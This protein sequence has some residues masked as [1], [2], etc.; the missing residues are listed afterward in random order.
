MCSLR[1]PACLENHG[2]LFWEETLY[3]DRRGGFNDS[4]QRSY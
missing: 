1:T 3:V 2:A 4:A